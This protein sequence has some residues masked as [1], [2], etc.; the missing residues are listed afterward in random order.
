MGSPTPIPLA[1]DWNT[2]GSRLKPKALELDGIHYGCICSVLT[3]YVH[4]WSMHDR[5][6][7]YVVLEIIWVFWSMPGDF[8]SRTLDL[9]QSTSETRQNIYLDLEN[10]DAAPFVNYLG[11]WPLKGF[12]KRNWHAITYIHADHLNLFGVYDGLCWCN[13]TNTIW[14]A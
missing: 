11:V 7:I 3:V 14:P 1:S 12:W 6:I 13:A 5:Y 2:A 9:H 10:I 4:M 8:I